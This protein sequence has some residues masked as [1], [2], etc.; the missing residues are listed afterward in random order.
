LKTKL[1][2]GETEREIEARVRIESEE[3]HDA[4]LAAMQ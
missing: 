1:V 3:E 4:E 2:K